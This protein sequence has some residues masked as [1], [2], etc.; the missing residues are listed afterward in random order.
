M[1]NVSK[2]WKVYLENA[3]YVSLLYTVGYVSVHWWGWENDFGSIRLFDLIIFSI[4]TIVYTMSDVNKRER[5]EQ[6]E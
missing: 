2:Y 3:W 1:S 6:T 5:R 4:L